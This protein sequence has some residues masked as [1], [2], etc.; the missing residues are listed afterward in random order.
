MSAS[1]NKWVCHSGH[2]NLVTLQQCHV[3]CLCKQKTVCMFSH[4]LKW[5]GSSE[6]H[7]AKANFMKQLANSIYTRLWLLDMVFLYVTSKLQ[8][9]VHHSGRYYPIWLPNSASRP[10]VMLNGAKCP[11][12]QCNKFHNY[13][14]FQLGKNV[15][16]KWLEAD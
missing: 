16:P 5:M 13:H 3:Q 1:I 11:I 14:Q 2:P 4:R 9:D 10:A 6:L 8:P 7:E 12:D 15:Q